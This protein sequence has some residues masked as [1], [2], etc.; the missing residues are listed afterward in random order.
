MLCN[1][2]TI[3]AM[4]RVYGYDIVYSLPYSHNLDSVLEVN[5]CLM[6]ATV[7]YVEFLPVIL[8]KLHSLLNS[9]ERAHKNTTSRCLAYLS[10]WVFFKVILSLL[11]IYDSHSFFEYLTYVTQLYTSINSYQKLWWQFDFLP[12]KSDLPF[13]LDT[14]WFF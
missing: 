4:M 13:C 12:L 6:F 5:V 3:N 10:A 11:K 14:H 9:S 2:C 8:S 7:P 1:H